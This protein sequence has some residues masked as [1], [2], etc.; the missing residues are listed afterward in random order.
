MFVRTEKGSVAG[1]LF[2]RIQVELS[3]AGYSRPG[4]IPAEMT[5]L[6]WCR[7]LA[8]KGLKVD[9]KP[10]DLDD[11]PS[12]IPLYAAIPTTIEDALRRTLVLMKGA[13]LSRDG[14]GD[15]GGPLHGH[16]V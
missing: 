13:Q 15:A 12:L 11:R 6:D 3:R 14:A 5:F 9:N 10:F 8:A 7:D 1:R 16:Q 2:Q 4:S